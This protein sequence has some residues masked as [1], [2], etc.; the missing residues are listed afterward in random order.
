MEERKKKAGQKTRKRGYQI[1]DSS[2]EEASSKP[3]S[4]YNRSGL[5]V[6]EIGGKGKGKREREMEWEEEK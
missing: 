6:T 5:K 4:K 3:A 2:G 1:A